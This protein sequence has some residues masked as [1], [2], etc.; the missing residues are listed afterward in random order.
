MNGIFSR[1]DWQEALKLPI[2]HLPCGS[3]HMDRQPIEASMEK[4]VVQSAVL[5]ATHQV[6]PFDM[7]V[8]DT[9][10]GQRIFSFLSVAWG[11]IADVDYES[12]KYRFLGKKKYDELC[13]SIFIIVLGETRFTVEAVKRV[14]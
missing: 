11:I 10:D 13:F 1:K 7:A 6:I 3:V 2:G 8:I 4:F 9:C 14:L 12:E 5:I